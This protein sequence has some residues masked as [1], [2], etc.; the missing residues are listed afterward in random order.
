MQ[1]DA[2]FTKY[3]HLIEKYGPDLVKKVG[4]VYQFEVAPAKG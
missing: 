4:F 1:S 2:L 3:G